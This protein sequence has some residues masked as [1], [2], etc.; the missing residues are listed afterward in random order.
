[1]DG[2]LRWMFT[3][4]VRTGQS[5]RGTLRR[6]HPALAADRHELLARRAGLLGQAAEA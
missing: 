2:M 5:M 3:M 1:M 6:Y 4:R